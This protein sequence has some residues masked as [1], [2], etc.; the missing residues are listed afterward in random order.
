MKRYIRYIEG[1]RVGEGGKQAYFEWM[2]IQ[3]EI[4]PLP[5]PQT[6]LFLTLFLSGCRLQLLK[7]RW[8]V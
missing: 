5:L 8:V 6:T 2:S 1:V 3:G 4:V 7:V